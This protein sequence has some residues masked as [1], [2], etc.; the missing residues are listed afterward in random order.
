MTKSKSHLWLKLLVSVGIVFHLICIFVLPNPE[1]IIYRKLSPWITVYANQLGF[2]TTWR[3]FSPNPLIRLLEY[4]VYSRT[5]EGE[6]ISSTH[7][8]P[9]SLEHEDFRDNYNRK[10]SSSMFLMASQTNF[11][12]ILAPRICKMHPQAET[13]SFYVVGYELPSIEKSVF[14]Q[15]SIKEL[16]TMSRQE[17]QDV[18]CRTPKD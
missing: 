12:T 6:L 1:S 17:V 4:D 14:L 18:D 16:G 9:E 10:I 2:N 15:K 3:F 7:R 13:I 8:Y 5:P 11:E